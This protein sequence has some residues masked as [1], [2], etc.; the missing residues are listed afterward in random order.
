MTAIASI[1]YQRLPVYNCQRKVPSWYP[2]QCKGAGSHVWDRAIPTH[3]DVKSPVRYGDSGVPSV[4]EP[5]ACDDGGAWV[6][7]RWTQYLLAQR[8]LLS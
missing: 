8:P 2:P 3:N 4:R 5:S 1:Q 6:A 7:S